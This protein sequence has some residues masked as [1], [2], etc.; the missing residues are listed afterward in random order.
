MGVTNF[1][2]RDDAGASKPTETRVCRTSRQSRH[3]HR[4]FQALFD[5]WKISRSKVSRTQLDVRTIECVNVLLLLLLK[6]TPHTRCT[7]R[8]KINVN[9]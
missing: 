1:V 2:A 3:H 5:S 8:F 4:I 6:N 7:C 9:Q